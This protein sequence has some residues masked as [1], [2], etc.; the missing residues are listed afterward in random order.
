MSVVD[1][2]PL[3]AASTLAELARDPHPRLV[4]HAGADD[5]RGGEPVVVD[6]EGLGVLHRKPPT[7]HV[8]R[9]RAA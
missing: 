2:F 6:G 8:R 9:D 5:L 3:G 1:S 4:L 7:L